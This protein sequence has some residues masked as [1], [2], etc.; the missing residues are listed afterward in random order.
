MVQCVDIDTQ[1]S[2]IQK[3]YFLLTLLRQLHGLKAPQRI[4]LKLAVLAQT[5]G[6]LSR[7]ECRWTPKLINVYTIN[8]VDT[9]KTITRRTRLSTVGRWPG[10]SGRCRWYLK[11]STPPHRLSALSTSLQSCTSAF[12]HCEAPA[13]CSDRGIALCSLQELI[14]RSRRNFQ[15]MLR[16]PHN[17]GF[18]KLTPNK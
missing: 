16:A 6:R 1:K 15:E 17:V 5:G 12:S 2:A 11:H 18:E 4:D 10:I 9:K 8:R 13:Q 14:H 3:S 7:D